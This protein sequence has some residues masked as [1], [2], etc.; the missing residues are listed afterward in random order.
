MLYCLQHKIEK[1]FVSNNLNFGERRLFELMIVYLRNDII[2]CFEN[3]Q[4]CSTLFRNAKG[5][6]FNEK[7][8]KSPK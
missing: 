4:T 1:E 8:R 6:F 3:N 5:S 7:R 2:S